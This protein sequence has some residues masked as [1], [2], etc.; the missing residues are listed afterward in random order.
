[1][2]VRSNCLL[3]DDLVV[4]GVSTNP[5]PRDSV[6]NIDP[7][8]AIVKAHTGDPILTYLLELYRG[9]PRIRIHPLETAVSKF[10]DLRRQ[11]P[12]ELPEL[13][14]RVMIQ[15]LVV[16]PSACARRAALPSLSSFPARTS[17]SI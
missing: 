17:A 12:I 10:A 3:A 6:G 5:E 1:M 13:R 11:L 4:L 2:T 16:L 14:R 15:S 9:M 7:Q 8:R